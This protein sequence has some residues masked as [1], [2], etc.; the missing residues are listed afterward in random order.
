MEDAVRQKLEA[1][2]ELNMLFVGRY[3]VGKSTL[4]NSLFYRKGEKYRMTAKE[5][6]LSACTRDVTPYTFEMEDVTVNI[7]DTP[8]LQDEN[9]DLEY[10][11]MVGQTCSNLHLIIYCKKMMEPMRP[12][13][14]R[15]LNKAFGSSSWHN[16][17]I[18]LTF[19]NLVDPPDPET[20][21]VEYFKHLMQ[22]DVMQYDVMQYDV[23]QYDVMQYDVQEF[24]RIS[25][26]LNINEELL[27]K[28]K[29]RIYPAGSVRHLKLPG[30][31]EDWRVDFWRGCLEV[32]SEEAAIKAENPKAE[33]CTVL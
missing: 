11:R 32:C 3:Q 28:L 5:G 27:K 30:M 15:I 21:K 10:L 22:Y 4:I 2:K 1:C 29:T 12:A 9:N 13:E 24:E 14:Y 23:M 8:G 31:G 18:A 19:A 26:A 6:K 17:I 7:Y 16:T 20:D 25:R 33:K